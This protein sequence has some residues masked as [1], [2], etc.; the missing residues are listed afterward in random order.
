MYTKLNQN[1]TKSLRKA[2]TNT[3]ERRQL[4]QIFK[5]ST[6]TATD[7]VSEPAKTEL[8]TLDFH[9]MNYAF[10]KENSYSNEKVS[11]MLAIMD[12]VFTRMLEK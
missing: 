3:E 10:C 4:A 12:H 6:I 7:P 5:L 1:E 9:Y 11:T 2:G 8:L